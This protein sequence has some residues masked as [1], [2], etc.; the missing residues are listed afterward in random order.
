MEDVDFTI[1]AS[2]WR[3]RLAQLEKAR[4]NY[5]QAC[6]TLQES[7]NEVVEALAQLQESLSVRLLLRPPKTQ[8]IPRRHWSVDLMVQ[9]VKTFAE[10]Y[11][12]P[13]TSD[14]FES[15]AWLPNPG[16]ISRKG[17]TLASLR[18]QAGLPPGHEGWGG[19]GRGGAHT[20]LRMKERTN[21]TPTTG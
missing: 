11:Q 16:T 14:D 20:K 18:R 1:S 8:K 17:L 15:V 13:P 19:R 9:A 21:D 6:V 4:A 3:K 12:R 10:L 2:A 7:I 5:Q